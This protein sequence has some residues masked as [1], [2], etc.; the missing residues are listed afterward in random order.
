MVCIAAGSVLILG[1]LFSFNEV[2][3]F[4]F[5]Q[6]KKKKYFKDVLR[7]NNFMQ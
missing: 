4:F 7:L 6:K 3:F 2:S 5:T 1:F